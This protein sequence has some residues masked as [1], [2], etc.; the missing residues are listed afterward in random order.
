MAETITIHTDRGDLTLNAPCSLA[1]A[2]DQLLQGTQRDP[3]H[4]A[5]AVNGEFV[6]RGDRADH[7]LA[8]G[9]T[10]L[11]FAPITGG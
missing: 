10:V 8:D 1:D 3:A 5:T 4:M 6:A 11:C 9:D 7:W 2:I